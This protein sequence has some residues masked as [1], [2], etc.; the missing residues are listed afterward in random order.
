[1]NSRKY[2]RIVEETTPKEN[3]LNNMIISFFIGGAVAVIGTF[4]YNTFTSNYNS[5]LSISLMLLVLIAIIALLTALGIA[6]KLFT[7]FKCGLI[8]PITGF[9]NSIASCI[10]DYKKEGFINIGSNTFKLAGSVL[11]YGIVS[12]II[13]TIIK[14]I[15]NV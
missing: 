2:Q 11:L 3:R 4:L 5:E 6:D 12:A 14:V 10:I 7:K 1:M 8:I 9:A 15:I 13:L